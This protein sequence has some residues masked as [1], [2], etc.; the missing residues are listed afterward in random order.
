MGAGSN[1]EGVEP[2]GGSGHF[3]EKVTITRREWL[4]FFAEIRQARILTRL[5]K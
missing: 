4:R 3:F 5:Q 2:D 1:G